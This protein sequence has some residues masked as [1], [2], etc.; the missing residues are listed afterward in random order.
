MTS[1]KERDRNIVAPID[2]N[3]EAAGN[4]AKQGSLNSSSV[5][6]ETASSKTKKKGKNYV[7][8]SSHQ[9]TTEKI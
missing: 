7:V 8:K 3:K 4:S 1:D 5:D 6:E 2:R 9:K